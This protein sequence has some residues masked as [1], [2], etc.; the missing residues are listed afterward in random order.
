MIIYKNFR[1][2]IRSDSR[3]YYFDVANKNQQDLLVRH[4]GRFDNNTEAI[5]RAKRLIDQI[6]TRRHG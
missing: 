4:Q 5:E 1:I 3:G 2:I 6:Q